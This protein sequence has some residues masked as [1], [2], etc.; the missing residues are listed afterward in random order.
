[1][2]FT[3]LA[4]AAA[5]AGTTSASPLLRRQGGGSGLP[6]NATIPQ[7]SNGNITYQ[8]V[9]TT[10]NGSSYLNATVE[11]IPQGVNNTGSWNVTYTNGTE[12]Y[13]GAH[14]LLGAFRRR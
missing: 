13:P 8:V 7:G 11:S 3:S 1:M 14:L 9:P 4:A 6:P 5:L 12:P 10:S 2:L